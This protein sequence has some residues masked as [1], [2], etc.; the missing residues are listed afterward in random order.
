MHQVACL[1]EF[2]AERSVRDG[3]AI[4]PFH[5]VNIAYWCGLA[6][7]EEPGEGTEPDPRQAGTAWLPLDQLDAH[8]VQPLA[9]ARWLESDP[10][11]RPI[12]LGVSRA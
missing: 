8:E 11:D 1:F 5:Q 12:S 4:R 7:G 10:S 9:L 6:E 2:M 3:S